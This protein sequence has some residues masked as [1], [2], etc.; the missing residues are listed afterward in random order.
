M[1]IEGATVR[2][3]SGSMEMSHRASGSRRRLVVDGGYKLVQPRFK[4]TIVDEDVEPAVLPNLD[5]RRKRL[6]PAGAWTPLASDEHPIATLQ[7]RVPE[8]ISVL[9]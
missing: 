8:G 3:D 6:Q 2:R 5:P 4:R 9:L 7:W 1:A